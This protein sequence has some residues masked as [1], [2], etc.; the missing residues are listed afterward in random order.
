[1]TRTI[2]VAI[3]IPHPWATELA[4]WRAKVGDPLADFV[5]PHIT[6]LPPTDL[7]D[8]R[9]PSVE[10]HLRQVACNHAPF[11]LHLRGTGTFRPVS[12]VVFVAVARGIAECERLADHVRSGPLLREIEFP[13]HPHVTIAHRVHRDALERAFDGLSG[14]DARFT[15]NGFTL[16]EHGH[17]GVWRPH[18]G[19]GFIPAT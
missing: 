10:E 18:R 8:D 14:F 6:L 5:P 12:D 19:F 7:S 15:V 11:E 13:Y 9:L 16:F 4:S 17:D 1:M 2:G 3:E